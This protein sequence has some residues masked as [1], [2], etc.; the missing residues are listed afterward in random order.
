MRKLSEVIPE[1][2]MK[3]T[4]YGFDHLEDAVAQPKIPLD[5]KVPA[6]N[7]ERAFS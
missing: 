2:V 7:R 3:R 6:L 4:K 5:L 1:Q